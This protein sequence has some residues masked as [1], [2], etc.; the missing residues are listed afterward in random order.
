MVLPRARRGG[1]AQI[2][3]ENDAELLGR[4]DVE[5][6]AGQLEDALAD[7]CQLAAEPL[8]KSAQRSC[9]D[10]DAGFLHAVEHGREREVDFGVDARDAWL[11]GFFAQSGNERMNGGGGGGQGRRR[12]LVVARGDVGQGLRGVRGVERVGEQ[13]ACRRLGR[14]ESTPM[15]PRTCRASFQSWTRLGRRRLRGARAARA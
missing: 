11:F 13:H 5:A 10:A 9:V 15:S 8:R 14:A 2:G 7:A 3:E 4:I 1:Q 12:R 6:L